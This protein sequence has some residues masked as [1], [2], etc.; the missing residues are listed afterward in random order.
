M[1]RVR[2]VIINNYVNLPSPFL[3]ESSKRSNADMSRLDFCKDCI[4]NPLKET[5]P[6]LKTLKEPCAIVHVCVLCCCSLSLLFHSSWSPS[7]HVMQCLLEDEFSEDHLDISSMSLV[8]WVKHLV[9]DA[10][11]NWRLASI[12]LNDSPALMPARNDPLCLF[13]S[14]SSNQNKIIAS[15]LTLSTL[16]MLVKRKYLPSVLST[17]PNSSNVRHQLSSNSMLPTKENETLLDD[18]SF[19]SH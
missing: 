4:A 2:H 12:H 19:I 7:L 16:P 1:T 17:F 15:L 18:D 10:S 11:S 13:M 9:D 8:E 14:P 3:V 6:L 5:C